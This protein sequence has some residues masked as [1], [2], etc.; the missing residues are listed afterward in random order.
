MLAL[1]A[2]EPDGRR[3]VLDLVCESPVGDG[4]CVRGGNE[5]RPEAVVHWRAGRVEGGLCDG[6]VLGPETESDCVALGSGDA[7]GHE[8]QL[9]GLGS[10]SDLVVYCKSGASEG[11]SGGEDG[12]EVHFDWL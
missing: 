10:N 8:L 1:G 5:A 2:V 3:G 6:V 9:A 11:S 7:V 12:R 4:V